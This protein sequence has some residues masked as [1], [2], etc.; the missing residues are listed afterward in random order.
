MDWHQENY[1]R[2]TY[3]IRKSVPVYYVLHNLELEGEVCGKLHLALKLCADSLARVI[4]SSSAPNSCFADASCRLGQYQLA[5]KS[6]KTRRRV[7]V[8]TLIREID[9]NGTQAFSA[10]AYFL[11]QYAKPKND[12]TFLRAYYFTKSF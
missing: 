1:Q 7:D 11:T 9:F 4:K 12:A 6:G 3:T 10:L 8:L 5:R 2:V